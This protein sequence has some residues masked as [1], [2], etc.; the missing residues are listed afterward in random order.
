MKNIPIIV[1][2]VLLILKLASIGSVTWV[3]VFAVPVVLALVW[4][5]GGA[6]IAGMI[7]AY[8]AYKWEKYRE[9]MHQASKRMRGEK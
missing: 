1:F 9:T 4:I 3:A 6:V 7:A 8:S 5:V 2:V